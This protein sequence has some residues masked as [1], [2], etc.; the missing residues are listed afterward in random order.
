MASHFT[1]SLPMCYGLS[2]VGGILE[3]GSI[4][5]LAVPDAREKEGTP[6][7]TW[8]SMVTLASNVSMQLIGSLSSNLIAP[9]FG[10]V[11]VVAPIYFS[12]TLVFNLIIFGFIL[13]L[14]FFDRIMI[15]GTYVIAIGT[16]LLQVVGPGIQNGQDIGEL[17]GHS[18]A[19]SWFLFLLVSMVVSTIIMVTSIKKYGEYKRIAILLIA[20]STS[21]TLNL[22]VSRAFLLNPDHFVLI[23]FIVIKVVSGAIYTYAIVVQS[24][25]VKQAKF[26]PLNA[27]TIILLNAIT[28]VIIWEDWRVISSWVG[29]VCVFLLLAL[30]CDLLLSANLL[31]NDNA[32]LGRAKL[33]RRF[34]LERSSGS[35]NLYSDIADYEGEVENQNI[36]VNKD[37]DLLTSADTQRKESTRRIAWKEVL[38]TGKSEGQGAVS[39]EY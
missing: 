8:L 6:I 4:A 1:Q 3:V 36:A 21:Y 7:S 12:A 38:S 28:G 15:V 17:L 16:V 23:S 22:T 11:S 13:G 27:T 39:W 10:P 2:A 35:R 33:M 30:G 29:Y 26:I 14:E 24:T 37:A 5:V 34:Q 25:A 19:L 18:Y 20:R 9:W 32:E 31:T